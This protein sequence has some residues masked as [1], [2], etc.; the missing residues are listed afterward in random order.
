MASST[1]MARIVDVQPFLEQYAF[2]FEDPKLEYKREGFEM[3]QAMLV[4]EAIP[5][6]DWNRD[7]PAATERN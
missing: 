2:Q 7:H 5:L 6:A 4:E 1:S 3:F